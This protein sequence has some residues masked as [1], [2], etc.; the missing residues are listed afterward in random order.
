MKHLS[1]SPCRVAAAVLSVA[2]T[3]TVAHAVELDTGNPDL[4][5]RWDNTV[6]Y[7]YA[8]R[9]ESQDSRIL[10][11]PNFDD[12]NR[13]F[14]KGTVSSR[15]DLLS[16]FDFIFRNRAGFRVS[17]AAWYDD[18]YGSLDNTSVATSNHLDDGM[19]AL[20]LSGTTKRFHKGLSAEILDAFLFAREEFGGM[21]LNLKLGRHTV[22][23]GE[24]LLSPI[25]GVG[26]GQAPLDLR[27]SLSVPGTEAKEL[28]LPRNALSA[29]LQATPELSLAAQ[30]FLDWKPFRIPE[31]GSYLGAF[32]MFLDGGESLIVAPGNRFLRGRDVEPS[33]HGDWGLSARWSPEWL[34]GTLG[35]YYRKTSDIQPQLHVTP[36]VATM[37]AAN[38][39][40]LGFAAL[41]PSAC[42]INPSAASISQIQ[43]GNIGNYHLAY[44]D[45]IDVFGISLSKSF[46]GVSVGAD[47][48]YR[49]NMPLN[50]D[51]V[52]I[53][54]AALAALTPGAITALPSSGNTGGA[55]GDT[56]HGVLNFLGTTGHT[57]VFDDASWIVE[58][59]WNRWQKV[60]KGEAVFKGRDGYTGV[61]KVSKDF[62]GLAA[63]YTPTWYQALPGVDLQLPLSYT[64]GLSG[65][66]AV[67]AGGNKGAGSYSVGLGADFYQKYRV[68]L[69]YVDFLGSYRTDSNGVITS[70][71]DINGL[72]KDRGFVSLTLKTTF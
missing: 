68:D 6:K 66:S 10:A 8:Y 62:F 56:W 69:K 52:T 2:S 27:K 47:L 9:T 50:S 38:C 33:K 32:D 54:P 67:S 60:N 63:N 59:Q 4:N 53:L 44:A 45:D 61:D 34:D 29:Q 28:L 48:S 3:I 35:F 20:G 11:S 16:E 13:N 26:Y 25:H 58:L 71:T 15:V 19:P 5:I 39:G 43:Q 64:I 31:A 40:A 36:A 37:P 42:Y 7:N 17:G 22:F 65:D 14:D 46:A 12:G 23:W 18:A 21:P 1:A 49:R 70:N 55:V 41:T 57:P 30:Y 51:A 72:I 24:A